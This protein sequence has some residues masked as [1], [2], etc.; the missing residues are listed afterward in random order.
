MRGAVGIRRALWATS[1][2]DS[3]KKDLLIVE[4][5]KMLPVV[6]LIVLMFL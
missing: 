3:P 4:I 2:L 5:D 1:V 6:L